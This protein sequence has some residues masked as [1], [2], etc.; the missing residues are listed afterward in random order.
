MA[1]AASGGEPAMAGVNRALFPYF[2]G[3]ATASDLGLVNN[4]AEAPAAG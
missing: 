3:R 2:T 1:E 4:V